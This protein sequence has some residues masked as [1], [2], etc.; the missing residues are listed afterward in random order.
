[1]GDPV[2][3]IRKVYFRVRRWKNVFLL[4]FALLGMATYAVNNTAVGS[5]GIDTSFAVST[6]IFAFLYIVSLIWERLWEIEFKDYL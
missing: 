1:M 5:G 2:E 3:N 6:I 4:M